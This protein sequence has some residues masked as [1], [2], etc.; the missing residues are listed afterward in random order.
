MKKRILALWMALCM[1]L[2]LFAACGE[3]KG[4]G[5]EEEIP[6]L[7]S[8]PEG[9]EEKLQVT[10]KEIYT[11][12][13]ELEEL[14]RDG[15]GLYVARGGMTARLGSD[16]VPGEWKRNENDDVPRVV[17]GEY[18]LFGDRI[19]VSGEEIPLELRFGES[20]LGFWSLDGIVYLAA[21]HVDF[22]PVNIEKVT[23]RYAVLY[24][25]TEKGLGDPVR[26]GGVSVGGISCGCDGKW[27][28]FADGSLLY[29]T[30]GRIL[31]NLG[32][33]TVF[34]VNP[35]ALRSIEPLDEKRVLLLSGKSLILLT[36][37]EARAEGDGEKE[38]RGMV[39]L[40]VLH[41]GGLFAEM[42]A[43]YNLTSDEKVE[44]REYESVEKLNLAVL[45]QEIDMVA[46]DDAGYMETYAKRGLLAPLDEVTGEAIS[47]DKIFPNLLDVCRM[48][49]EIYMIPA[50]VTVEGMLLPETVVEEAGGRFND[51]RDLIATLDRLEPQ[52]FYR[53]QTKE[54]ALNQ[55]LIHGLASWVDREKAECRFDDE[56]FLAMLE[57][58]DRYAPDQDTV[59]ANT[60]GIRPLFYPYWE[61][62][63]PEDGVMEYF[64]EDVKG[65]GETSLPYGHR[66]ALFPAPTG[67]NAGFAVDPSVL[68]GVLKES[69]VKKSAGAFLAWML[70]GETQYDFLVKKGRGDFGMPVNIPAFERMVEDA[71]HDEFSSLTGE[72]I[73]A[74]CEKGRKILESADHFG[75]GANWEIGK[76][77]VEEALRF[78]AHEI[79]ARKAAEYIQNRVSIY[80]AEQG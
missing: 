30:D 69:R 34:G 13:E 48:E 78:F 29:R 12:E 6:V 40:G 71:V 16:F 39:T 19:L 77:V 25:L 58:C 62:C 4:G 9:S 74:N 24:P 60:R 35:S 44:V 66:A 68:C 41:Y 52:N 23:G 42:I 65:S 11:G 20:Y 73:R 38:G 80:L 63:R 8:I 36:L 70:S 49:G 76:V 61:I 1:T 32:N 14:Y 22:D 21:Q 53:F 5:A 45:N 27:N 67:K 17:Y 47:P 79:T 10:G 26:A 57:F 51:M 54:L 59:S 43:S 50:G 2:L 7:F 18:A 64:F 31:Q 55:I 56:D 33:L 75:G 28:Y 37:G 3:K 72:E 15:D 46:A